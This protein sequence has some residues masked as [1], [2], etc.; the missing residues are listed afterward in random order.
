M[1]GWTRAEPQP[2]QSIKSNERVHR[3]VDLTPQPYSPTS[4]LHLMYKNKTLRST[5]ASYYDRAGRP[6]TVQRGKVMRLW[7]S[8]V[9][10]NTA[11]RTNWT[12]SGPG[13]LPGGESEAG[14]LPAVYLVRPPGVCWALS[15]R[16]QP[17]GIIAIIMKHLTRSMLMPLRS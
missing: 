14:A 5:Q 7:P 10:E 3:G 13:P 4:I 6:C 2:I 9:P 12:C 1:T 11:Q 17:D 16:A 8:M 15:P